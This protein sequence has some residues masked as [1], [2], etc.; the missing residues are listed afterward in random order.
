MGIILLF[1][2]CQ[3]QFQ[4]DEKGERITLNL[5]E[6]IGIKKPNAPIIA[7]DLG[8][9]D[10]KN[11]LLKDSNC[12]YVEKVPNFLSKVETRRNSNNKS[13]FASRNKR[14]PKSDLTITLQGESYS[15]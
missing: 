8:T 12:C 14:T 7:I 13:S 9:L 15:L 2:K 10:N 6:E 1:R 5:S 11:G 3:K 4:L